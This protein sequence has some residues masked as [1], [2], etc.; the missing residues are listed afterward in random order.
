MADL[1]LVEDSAIIRERFVALFSAIPNLAVV[2]QTGNALEAVTEILRL[3]PDIAV[4]DIHLEAG[5]GIEVLRLIRPG[6]PSLVIVMM[7][8][9]PT[10]AHRKRCLKAGA[11]HF[12]DKANE[13]LQIVDVVRAVAAARRPLL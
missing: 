1:F 4:L 3:R 10:A 8:T 12:F 2:G 9:D 6:I 5:S 13:H 11:D 7:T